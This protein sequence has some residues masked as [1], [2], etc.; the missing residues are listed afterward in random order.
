MSDELATR[1]NLP[2]S[3]DVPL[4]SS[5]L[6]GP[7]EMP[8]VLDAFLSN[9]AVGPCITTHRTTPARA[10]DTAPFPDW[11]RPELVEVLARRG[12]SSLYSH[13]REALDA[14]H[15]GDDIVVV[16]PTASGKSLCYHLPVLQKVLEDPDARALYI[17]PTKALSQDQYMTV[18]GY[19]DDM[20]ADIRTFTFDG[21][22][23]AD[24]RQAVRSHGH[25]VVSNPDMIHTGILP[26]HTKWV[27]LFRNLKY[28]VIDELHTY[29]GVF[30]SHVANVIRRLK[31]IAAFH[32]ARPQFICCSATIAN[33]AE[34]AAQLIERPVRAVERN[35]APEGERHLLFYNPPVV[36]KQLGIR[37][38][39]LHAARR[40]AISLIERDIPTIVFAPSRLNVEVLLRYLREDLAH[41]N[42]DPDRVQGYRGGYLPNLRRSI[43]RGLRSGDIT[44]VVATNALE[45]GI[46]IG[47]LSACVVAGY[48]GS[49]ASLWQQSG[50]AG[51]RAEAALTIFVGPV[52]PGRP[53]HRPAPGLLLRSEP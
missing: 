1:P 2:T 33:P 13:Q 4:L 5:E 38:S 37:A 39:Y 25:I 10:A 28:V 47:H 23:P 48:P 27:K 49:V 50:R 8:L 29:R 43:E 36:N 17:F 3:I 34:H 45:L 35:G 7:R 24:A 44:G 53:V 40:F 30:G 12:V 52:F 22:T 6:I 19:I 42:I 18:H 9:P 26:H 46:D 11:M 31:R 32:G 41:R 15:A 21:D 16:T 51:R 14:V 20:D